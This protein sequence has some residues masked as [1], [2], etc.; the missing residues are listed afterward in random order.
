MGLLYQPA[1]ES[2]ALVQ[3][4]FDGGTF[5]RL[6]GEA[7]AQG[8]VPA[9]GRIL[10]LMLLRGSDFGAPDGEAW[11]EIFARFPSIPKELDEALARYLR[12]PPLEWLIDDRGSWP[13]LGPLIDAL[14]RFDIEQAEGSGFTTAW[15][16]ASAETLHA[17]SYTHLDVYKRQLAT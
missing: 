12:E 6:L 5:A 9:M 13:S 14:V 15:I 4:A 11:D 8:N 16:L 2:N 17:V 10:A 7:K 1:G 3:R